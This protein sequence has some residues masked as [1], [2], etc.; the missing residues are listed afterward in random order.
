M[1]NNEIGKNVLP[2]DYFPLS[3]QKKSSHQD[4]VID[5]EL[6]PAS[7]EKLCQTYAYTI[8]NISFIGNSLHLAPDT[9]SSILKSLPNLQILSFKYCPIP[10]IETIWLERLKELQVLRIEHC[11]DIATLPSFETLPKL[12]KLD[13]SGSNQL[14]Q[15]QH[16]IHP[17]KTITIT[18]RTQWSVFT[19]NNSGWTH[20]ISVPPED[21]YD[22]D[23]LPHDSFAWEELDL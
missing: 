19:K 3:E 23:E 1:N 21:D 7:L 4:L 18:N 10:S 13:V 16:S 15:L 12:V 5:S 22:T 11:Q 8:K 14:A 17:N 2:I 20:T 9:L 6:E